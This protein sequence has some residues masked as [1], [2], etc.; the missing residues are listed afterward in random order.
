[1]KRIDVRCDRGTSMIELAICL[2]VIALLTIGIIEIGRFTYFSILAAHAA[3]A[4]VQYAAQNLQTAAD[5][6]ASGPN[7]TA[8]AVA[9][10]QGLSNWRVTSGLSCT[11]NNAAAPCPANNTGVVSPNNFYYVS[12][13][14][15]GTFNSLLKYP[16]IPQ[17]IPVTGSAIMRVGNQ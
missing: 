12:V 16:G 4:G 11:V 5:A 6:S 13:Q 8:A 9:D 10:G 15:T 1:M 14:V 17:Q 3:R 2:P 7:T